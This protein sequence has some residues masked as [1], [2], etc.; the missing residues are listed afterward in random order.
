MLYLKLPAERVSELSSYC[1]S[2]LDSP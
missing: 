1:R 2:V